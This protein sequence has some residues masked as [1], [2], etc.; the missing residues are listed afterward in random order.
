MRQNQ[1]WIAA[2]IIIVMII[3]IVSSVRQLLIPIIVLGLIFVLYKLPPK[4]WKLIWTR[5]RLNQIQ[6]SKQAKK[7]KF[8][9]IDGNK[10]KDPDD[11]PKRM[12]H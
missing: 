8:R 2:V 11:P 6:R 1:K 10:N 9:V 4:R 3:G 5:M 7:A 12:Y